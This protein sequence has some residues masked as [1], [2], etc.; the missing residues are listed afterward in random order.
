[1]YDVTST[2]DL[3]DRL[4]EQAALWQVTPEV[5]QEALVRLACEAL[6]RGQDSPGVVQLAA[7]PFS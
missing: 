1:M 4:Y 6:V 2:G 7:M 5:G 3:R